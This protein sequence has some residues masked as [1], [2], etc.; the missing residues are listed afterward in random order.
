MRTKSTGNMAMK[1]N[2]LLIMAAAAAAVACSERVFPEE[3]PATGV[4]ARFLIHEMDTRAL[5]TDDYR[6]CWEAFTDKVSVFAKSDNCLF[7]ATCGGDGEFWLEGTLSQTT[8]RYYALYPYDPDASNSTGCVT[9]TLPAEQ[10]AIPNQFSNIVAVVSTD[11]TQ[12]RFQNCVTL[13]E[14]KLATAGVNRISFRGNNG[15]L[16]AG[17]I[18]MTIPSKPE[19]SVPDPTIISGVKEVSISDEGKELAPGTYYL[20]IAPQT[21]NKGVTITLS[22]ENGYAEKMTTK[23]VTANRSKR[24][25][26]GSIDSELKPYDNDFFVEWSDGDDSGTVYSGNTKTLLYSYSGINSLIFNVHGSAAFTV[27]DDGSGTIA[28]SGN[29]VL[30]RLAPVPGS[31]GDNANNALLRSAARGSKDSPVDLST[32]NNTLFGAS[33]SGV[34]TANCY[35]VR[36]PGWYSFPLVYGNAIKNGTPNTN[37]YAPSVSGAAGLSPF[38]CADGSGITGPYINGS[39]SKAVSARIEW[40]DAPGLVADGVEL[41]SAGGSGDRIVFNVP[42]ATIREGNAVISALDASGGVVWSWHIWVCGASQSELQPVTITNKA[43]NSY[44]FAQ[45]NVGWVAPYD[46]LQYQ[47]REVTLTFAQQGGKTIEFK[48]LQTGATYSNAIGYCPFYQWGRK[49]PFAASDG[50]PNEDPMAECVKK[51]WYKTSGRDTTGTRALQ[52]G[53]S[54]AAYIAHP[55]YYNKDSGGDGT[56]SNLWNATQDTFVTSSTNAANAAPIVKTVYDPCP[57]GTCLPPVGAWTAFTSSNIDGAFNYGYAFFAGPDKTGG[58]TF[59]PATGSMS[60]MNLTSTKVAASL[61]KVGTG[62]SYWSGNAN[63]K[64]SGFNLNCYNKGAPT[65]TYGSNRQYVFAIR[66]AIEQ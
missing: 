29:E 6:I 35:V 62:F 54:L 55:S 44:K 23:A 21:F 60:T 36:A 33:L 50:T 47:Q 10:K 28:T 14:V 17:R 15:E 24:L 3:S 42:E 18:R 49:D 11:N 61:S 20:A 13:V 66:P 31:G 37:A 51:T 41:V 56:Y 34:N 12:L 22:G 53:A 30:Y 57:V 48:L 1:R 9:T 5:L 65:N 16:I 59:Y 46:N 39:G 26:A 8:S 43:G 2:L 40:Q 45:M 64:T 58:T 63:N 25:L 19:E 32:D 52:M 27:T 4:P 7:T 38:V